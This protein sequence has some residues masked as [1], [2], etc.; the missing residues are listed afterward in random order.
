MGRIGW[1]M[2]NYSGRQ[3]PSAEQA[4]PTREGLSKG[5]PVVKSGKKV[6][7]LSFIQEHSRQ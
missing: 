4:F 5:L 6:M 2:V 7:F 3:S 1:L